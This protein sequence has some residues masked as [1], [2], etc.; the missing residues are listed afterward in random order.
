MGQPFVNPHPVKLQ[1]QTPVLGPDV[2]PDAVPQADGQVAALV[3]GWA[4]LQNVFEMPDLAVI[5]IKVVKNKGG[6]QLRVLNLCSKCLLGAAYSSFG[7]VFTCS[8]YCNPWQR[9]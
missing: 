5:F 7:S 6:E 2:N 4:G 8:S 9:L 3:C 1:C